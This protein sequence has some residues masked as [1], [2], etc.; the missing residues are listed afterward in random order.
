MKR[1]LD[2]FIPSLGNFMTFKFEHQDTQKSGTA[3]E[4]HFIIFYTYITLTS[5]VIITSSQTPPN[6]YLNIMIPA[7][8]DP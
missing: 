6:P 3:G 1:D 7:C 5:H 8:R 2:A 4:N